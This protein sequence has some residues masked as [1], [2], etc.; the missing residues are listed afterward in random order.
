MENLNKTNRRNRSSLSKCNQVGQLHQVEI[1]VAK[2][3]FKIGNSSL[4]AQSPMNWSIPV[5]KLLNKN[6]NKLLNEFADDFRLAEFSVE[7]FIVRNI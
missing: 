4:Y 1:K 3:S 6:R 5:D 7:D 2:R